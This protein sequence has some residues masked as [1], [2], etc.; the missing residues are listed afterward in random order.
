MC[1]MKL[2]DDEPWWHILLLPVAVPALLIII[3]VWATF[4][5]SI[6]AAIIILWLL[7]VSGS[8]VVAA[9]RTLSRWLRRLF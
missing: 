1:A 6:A 5:P 7:A 8:A 2:P 9:F 4:I 3:Y